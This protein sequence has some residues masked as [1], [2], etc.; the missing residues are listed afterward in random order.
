MDVLP[1]SRVQIH[2]PSPSVVADYLLEDVDG[3][4]ICRERFW[5]VAFCAQILLAL[6]LPSV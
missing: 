2:L 1:A 4:V 6:G 3:F 5:A